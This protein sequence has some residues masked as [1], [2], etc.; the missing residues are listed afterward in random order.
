M[1]DRSERRGVGPGYRLDDYSNVLLAR[2]SSW[3]AR[4]T[5]QSCVVGFGTGRARSS[6]LLSK[7]WAMQGCYYHHRVAG[8][9]CLVY[10]VGQFRKE[11]LMGTDGSIRSCTFCTNISS[12]RLTH[13]QLTRNGLCYT[14]LVIKTMQYVHT[15]DV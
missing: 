14:S 7:T 8:R 12:L 9:L 15:V 10:R 6:S 1:C 2:P 4:F 3:I 11:P 5:L 13:S